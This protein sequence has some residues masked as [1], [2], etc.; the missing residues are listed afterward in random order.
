MPAARHYIGERRT[1]HETRQITAAARNLLHRRAKQHHGIG[2]GDSGLR[3]KREFALA[4]TKLH[5]DR[6]KRQAEPFNAAAENFNRRIEHIEAR[7]G[8]VLEA[9]CKQ[10]DLRRLWR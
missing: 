7:L 4:G 10:A 8:E 2:T 3:T 5:L 6:T 9:L 1:T